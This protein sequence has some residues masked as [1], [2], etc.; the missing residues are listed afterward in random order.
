M[1]IFEKRVAFKP[2]EYPDVMGYREAIRLSRWDVEEFDFE[3]DVQDFKKRL[4]DQERNVIKN[5]MLAISQIEAQNVKTFWAKIGD[6]LPKPEIG[7]VGMTMAENEVTHSMAYSKLLEILGLNTDFQDL[8]KSPVIEG[9]VNYLNK[10]L[11]KKA[12]TDDQFKTLS[13]MLFTLFV[14]RV[15]LFSQFAIIKSFRRQKNFLKSIDNV[16]LSTQKDELVHSQFGNYLLNKIKT[17]NPDWFN[18]EFLEVVYK[19]CEKAFKAEEGIIKWIFEQGDLDFITKDQVVEFTKDNFNTSLKGM[20]LKPLF[21]VEKEVLQ[22]L[23]WFNTEI[24][25]Y[26][27]NDFFNTKSSNYNKISVKP[28]DIK[29]SIRNAN[30]TLVQ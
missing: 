6:W 13:L 17:E 9:R 15:S 24:Y 1:N 23:E 5:T 19:A 3:D 11:T 21:Q 7:L 8:L 12:E 30:S 29:N 2:F 16:V 18:E 25:A 27:R 10:Y 14:E 20:G 28:K 26:T 22:P 4:T